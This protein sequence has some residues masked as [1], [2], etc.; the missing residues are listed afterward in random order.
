MMLMTGPEFE[1]TVSASRN[2]NLVKS[3]PSTSSTLSIGL[4]RL[5]AGDWSL[6]SLMNIP[7]KYQ[8]QIHNFVLRIVGECAHLM[9]MP[10][11]FEPDFARKFW[12]I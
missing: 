6:T 2:E 10:D 1:S 9:G 4:S 5:N 7:F 12:N 11:D 3:F 8:L